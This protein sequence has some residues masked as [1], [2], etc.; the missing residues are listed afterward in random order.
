[1]F[2]FSQLTSFSVIAISFNRPKLCSL[3]VWNSF[4]STFAG[5][6]LAGVAPLA[7]FVNANN[8]VYLANIQYSTIEV[9]YQGSGSPINIFVGAT[10]PYSIFV[11][12]ADD[13]Y[14]GTGD[15]SVDKWVLN[16]TNNPFT[17]N[18]SE[19]CFYVFID[20]NNSLHCSLS[21][22]HQ[23]IKRSLN[24]SDNNV[25]V[26]AGTGCPGFM[27]DMLDYPLG[28]FI[29]DN[30]NVYVAD[31]NNNRIQLFQ[32][33]ELNGTIMAGNGAPETVILN[34]PTDVVLDAD[35]YLFIVDSGNNRIVGSGPNGFRCIVGCS[36]AS[37]S[38]P[39]QLNGP[40]SIAFDSN[41]NIYVTDTQNNRV[42]NFVLINNPCNLT[43]TTTA[44][45]TTMSNMTT[46]LQFNFSQA[47]TTSMGNI[48]LISNRLSMLI[49]CII[50]FK[51]FDH[52]LR[53]VIIS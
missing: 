33:G 11:T 4:G 29:D 23:V 28:I 41:G 1:T 36:G 18:V 7:V 42:Q 48:T 34:Y 31:S 16:N 12:M 17:L 6:N 8:T 52:Q 14:T 19:P 38:G 25:L 46:T 35:G 15:I 3:A 37:G 30:F 49:L 43:T 32:P 53:D 27:L 26:V 51:C 10:L 13:I 24:S 50:E 2:N 44:T 20:T 39:T 22:S 5:Q 21:A 40:Q 9:W 47:T 45:T